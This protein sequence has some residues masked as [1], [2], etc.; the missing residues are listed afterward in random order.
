VDDYEGTPE[1]PRLLAGRD[2]PAAYRNFVEMFPDD[3]ACLGYV[4]ALR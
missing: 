4:E 1:R 3:D 2:Y